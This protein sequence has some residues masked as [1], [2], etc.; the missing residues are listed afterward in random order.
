M[1]L[2]DLD[3]AEREIV[4][5]CLRA[6]AEGPFF[7]DWEFHTLFGLKRDEVKNVLESWPNVDESEGSV[8]LAINNSLNNLLGYPWSARDHEWPKFISV[9]KEEVGRVFSKWRGERIG[10]YFKGLM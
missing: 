4:K 6:A 7:D 5:E 8:V 2:T 3:Q 1:P 9:S 10:H